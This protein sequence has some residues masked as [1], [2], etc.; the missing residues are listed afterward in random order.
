MYRFMGLPDCIHIKLPNL[1]LGGTDQYQLSTVPFAENVLGTKQY[2]IQF[3]CLVRLYGC[4]I[5]YLELFILL[6]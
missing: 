2:K 5:Y 1:D 3:G 4:N 6:W